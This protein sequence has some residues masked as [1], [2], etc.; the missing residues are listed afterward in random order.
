[1]TSY[2]VGIDLGTTNSAV[3]YSPS[4]RADVRIF[5]VPQLV[6]PGE[7]APRP[8]LPSFLYLPQGSEL[9]EGDLAL[10][11]DGAIDH[12]VGELARRLGAK[13]PGRLVSSAKSWLCHTGV[14][15]RAAILPWGAPDEVPRVSPVEASARYLAHVR[16]AWDA[17]HP[18]APLA[19]QEVVLTVPASFDEIARDL[20]VEAARVAGLGKVRLLEEPQAALYDFLGAHEADLAEELRAARLVLVVDV[21][22]GTTDLTLVRVHPEGAGEPPRLERIAVGEHLMLGGDNMDVTLARHVER[23]AGEG[24][25]LDASEW[26]SLVQAARFA[27]ERLL[28]DD[29]PEEMGVPIHRRG[30][31][32]IGG[33]RTITLKREEARRLLLDGFL[34]FTGVDEVPS[35]KGRAA[36]TELGLPYA[37]DPA[38]SRHLCAFLRRH[39]EAAA[40][41][42]ARIHHGLPRPDVL[43]LNGGVFNAPHVAA[44]LTEVLERWYGGDTVPLLRH[45]SLD[46]AV[47]R[48]AARYG[49]ARHG[50]GQRIA[51]G[52]ARAYYVGVQGKGGERQAFCVAPRGME[53]GATLEVADRTFH[54]L[55]D[56]PVSFPLYTSTGDR[57]H[58]AGELI[59]IDDELETLPPLQTVLRSSGETGEIPV[60]LSSTLTEI[61]T[62]EL[63]LSAADPPRR[64]R[65]EFSVR[66]EEATGGGAAVASIDELPP[67]FGEAREL[68][69]VVYGKQKKEV[70]PKEVKHLWRSLERVL[71]ER[72]TWSS[73]VSRE[74]FGLALAGAQKRRRSADHERIWF[75]LAGWTLRPGFGAPLDDWRVGE[76]WKLHPAG[77]QYVTD[78]A[79]WVEW[80]I[81]WRRVAGGL[82]K[83]QQ[84]RLFEDVRPWLEPPKG[85]FPMRPRGPTAH[86][87][88]EMVRLLASLERLSASQK[89]EAGA[90]ILTRLE[91][92]S[93]WPLGRL[94][95]RQPFHGSAHDVVPRPVA[96]AW[97]QRLLAL[98][99]RKADGAP[100]AAV[101]LARVTGDRERDLDAALRDTVARRL[102]QAKAP[103]TWV[104]MVREV[105]ELSAQDEVRV[106]GDTLPAGLRLA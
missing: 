4:G 25:K 20:T 78:K 91:G 39:V 34:P 76:L 106:F 84:E 21:G 42:G 82:D 18:D 72:D 54:L 9:I 15:R 60:R 23:Q 17:A 30:S 12:V 83:A 2:I 8:L 41:T 52:S 79:N 103:D 92:K 90:W 44:R 86:G 14:D 104:Q 27:K 89:Q 56:R 1:M 69:E 102:Q 29:A 85:R 57:T 70:D 32:L 93:W 55:L 87:H 47:A 88:D 66:G 7:V 98:D 100:F 43:L 80:W 81:L 26:T 97:L 67:K 71:G 53:E 49:L 33:S 24:L 48:G 10:P 105:T 94:G 63:Y 28:S 22:G 51:G 58:A 75:Q 95:A 3:A 45:A 6:A 16:G 101:Q 11:W 59:D 46:L 40:E 61:G 68:L 5:D 37:S 31:K 35:R 62:L 73:A 64:W 36:L 13:V 99:W 38:I 74:L 19:D 96:E 50:F 65:L 77:V